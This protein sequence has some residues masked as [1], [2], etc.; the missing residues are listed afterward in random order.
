MIFDQLFQGEECGGYFN[1]DGICGTGLTCLVRFEIPRNG[2][3]RSQENV[4]SGQCVD[5]NSPL[6][7]DASSED[8]K[9]GVNCR[10]GSLGI[11]A[12]ALY[13]PDFGAKNQQDQ[14]NNNANN[15]KKPTPPPV[16][17]R[18]RPQR[19]AVTTVQPTL[20]QI[21]FGNLPNLP[22]FQ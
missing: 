16:T 7:P 4:A 1:R 19:P 8:L 21:L 10:P 9:D 20:I 13:C 17:P 12:N 18:P 14:R 11:L 6:C 3:G 2:D 15:N 22:P 5:S